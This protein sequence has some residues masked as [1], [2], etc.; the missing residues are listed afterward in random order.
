[1]FINYQALQDLGCIWANSIDQR[2]ADYGGAL[3][4]RTT[5]HLTRK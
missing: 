4:N 3:F 2:G 5:D 1:M